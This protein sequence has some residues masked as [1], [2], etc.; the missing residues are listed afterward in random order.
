M[1]I[2]TYLSNLKNSAFTLVSHMDSSKKDSVKLN[3]PY[4]WEHQE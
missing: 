1:Q 3:Q 2:N 4:C